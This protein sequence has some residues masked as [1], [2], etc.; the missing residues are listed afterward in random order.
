M[1]PRFRGLF[2]CYPAV[3]WLEIMRTL[4]DRPRKA[5]TE[6]NKEE[7]KAP[8]ETSAEAPQSEPT[9]ADSFNESVVIN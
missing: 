7:T 5:S 3:T 9:Q 4:G 2:S 8:V 1:R 6:P